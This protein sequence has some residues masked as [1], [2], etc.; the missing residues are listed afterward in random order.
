MPEP[1]FQTE[2]A[3][4]DKIT[5]LIAEVEARSKADDASSMIDY[6]EAI[7]RLERASGI[8]TEFDED[9]PRSNFRRGCAN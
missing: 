9:R 8:L 6:D 1:Q 7:I 4:L 3:L 5:A 2:Q